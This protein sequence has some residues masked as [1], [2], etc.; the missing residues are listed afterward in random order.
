[1]PALERLAARRLQQQ[2]APALFLLAILAMSI[3]LAWQL[4]QAL[5]LLDAPLPPAPAPAAPVAS[6]TPSPYLAQLFGPAPEA[7]QRVTATDLQLSLLAS[8]MHQQPEQSAA[9]IA[10]QGGKARRVTVGDEIT[11]GVQLT[12]VFKDHVLLRRAGGTQSLHF[13]R[14]GRAPSLTAVP[15]PYADGH[16]H[17]SL[18]GFSAY[19]TPSLP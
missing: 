1:M 12:A 14:S 16:T 10:A 4:A 7:L 11:P 9:F 5:A 8:F 2:A 17:A 19:D 6:S 3:S 18:P 13:A 15:P